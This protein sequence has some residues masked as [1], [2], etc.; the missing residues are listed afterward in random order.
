MSD[1]VRDAYDTVA[2][3]YTTLF[4]DELDRIPAD[5][6][7]ITTFAEM[8]GP[9][10]APVAD[11]GCGPG[12]VTNLLSEL[13]L[14]PVG[15]DI[16]PGL[17]TEARRAFPHLRFR[18]GDLTAPDIATQSLGGIVSRHSLIHLEPS[19][20]GAVFTQW[21]GLLIPGAP[22][23]VSF[24]AAPSAEG[25]G[26]PF[27]HAVVTA[28]ALCPTTVAHQLRTAGFTEPAITTRSPLAGQRPLDHATILARRPDG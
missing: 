22:V 17:L 25:H 9:F 21:L 13:G 27:D 20:L 5:R 12:H 10:A 2:A 1:A 4:L 18:L 3:S 26:T 23:L 14:A 7:R 28:Y 6:E 11:L 8:T 16:S 15:Y 24:F 19:R